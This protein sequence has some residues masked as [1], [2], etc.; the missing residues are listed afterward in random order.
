MNIFLLATGGY[1]QVVG[2]GTK[3]SKREAELSVA[4]GKNEMFISKV[5]YR[6]CSRSTFGTINL[7]HRRQTLP[8]LGRFV[9]HG[10]WCSGKK[11]CTCIEV[12]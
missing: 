9:L 11:S 5:V 6:V 12:E 1:Q 8:Y 7:Q 2:G 10:W 3:Y 4:C